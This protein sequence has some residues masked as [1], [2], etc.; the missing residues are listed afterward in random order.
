M[1]YFL[2]ILNSQVSVKYPQNPKN[3]QSTELISDFLVILFTALSNHK[4]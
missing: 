2:K 4:H 1:E 3:M